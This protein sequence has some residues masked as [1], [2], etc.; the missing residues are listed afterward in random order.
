MQFLTCYCQLKI[1][2]LTTFI[3][4]KT[5]HSIISLH[6]G[7]CNDDSVW[8]IFY[9]C[10]QH[11]ICT[12][13]PLNLFLISKGPTSNSCPSSNFSS[14]LSPYCSTNPLP[15]TTE[16]ME[17]HRTSPWTASFGVSYL[18]LTCA[19]SSQFALPCLRPVSG[20]SSTFSAYQGTQSEHVCCWVNLIP[21]ASVLIV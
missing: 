4:L 15:Q 20:A 2:W 3:K 21:Q 13:V 18:L 6:L 14:H 11:I 9:N 8:S 5:E 1:F 10:I 7:D 19:F 12:M 16:L 17:R